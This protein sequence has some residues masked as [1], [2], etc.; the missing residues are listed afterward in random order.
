M[1]TSPE[2]ARAQR[3]EAL[4]RQGPVQNWERIVEL[5]DALIEIRD[6]VRP[7][8]THEGLTHTNLRGWDCVQIARAVL[9]PSTSP[10]KGLN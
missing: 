8:Q 9:A 10:T 4:S 7:V 6:G 5:E 2:A 1:P 3:I